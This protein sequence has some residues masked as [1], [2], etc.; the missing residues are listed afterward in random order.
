MHVEPFRILAAAPEPP[1]DELLL[2][3][4]AEFREIDAERAL[5]RLDRLAERVDPLAIGA[6]AELAALVDVLDTFSEMP[7][8]GRDPCELMLDVVLEQRRGAGLLLEVVRNEVARRAGIAVP[9]DIGSPHD[10]A[11]LVLDELVDAYEHWCDL[12]NAIR[13]AQLR[14]LLPG[15]AALVE[16]HE[17]EAMALLARLN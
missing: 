15:P 4:A 10:T 6:R 3:L 16:R 14:L 8:D 13:A 5:R 9:F 12:G 1:L 2:A 11:L 17:R 7:G